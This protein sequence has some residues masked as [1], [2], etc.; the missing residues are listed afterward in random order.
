MFRNYIKTAWRNLFKTKIFSIINITGLAFGLTVFWLITLF[1]ADELSYDKYHEKSDRIFRVVSHGR[2]DGGSFDI[3]GT[4]GPT[5]QALKNEYPEIEQTVRIAPGA[6]GV[7]NNQQNRLKVD[8]IFYGDSSFFSVFTYHFIAG[9]PYRAL[10]APQSIVLTKGLAVKLFG[11]ADAALNKS[12]RFQ[13]DIPSLI[14]GVIEDVPDNS[15]FTFE[16]IRSFPKDFSPDWSNFYLYTYLLLKNK[17]D[18]DVLKKKLP[19]FVKKYFYG[20]G[21]DIKYSLE[22]QPLTS[23]HLHS[24]VSYEP[25]VT[26]SMK[27]IYVFSLI[28]LLVLLIAIINYINITTARASV[29]LKEIAIRKIIGSD[30]KNL[31][32]LFLTESFLIILCAILLSIALAYFLMPVFNLLTVKNLNPWSFGFMHTSLALVIVCLVLNLIGGL[33]PALLLS[34]F[35]IIPALRNKMGNHSFQVFFRKSLVILQFSI[36]IIMIVATIVIYRQL[37]FMTNTDLG[38]DKNEVVTFSFNNQE[39]KINTHDLKNELLKKAAITG[40]AFTGSPM[41]NNDH[42]EMKA[43]NAEKNGAIDANI[44]LAN[45]LTIDEDYIP[46]MRIKIKQGRNFNGLLATDS[47]AVIINEAFAK[48]K[49]WGNAIGK[50][51]QVPADSNRGQ[52][53]KTVIGVTKDFH[54]YSLQHKIEPMVM[55][56]PSSMSNENNAYVR[57]SRQNIGETIQF[58][59]NTFQKF[60]HD[61]PFEYSFLDQNFRKQYESEEKQGLLLLAFTG[62]TITIACLGLF[63]LITFTTNQR[64]KEVGIRKVLG[65]SAPGLVKLLSIELLKLVLLSLLVAFPVSWLVMNT[66]LDEF[67]YRISITWWMFLL[68]GC[69]GILITGVT[70]SFQTIKAATANPVKSLRAE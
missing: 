55:E 7:I 69:I 16:A 60:D 32:S 6:G 26:R 65:A 43:F 17:N 15:H 37:H 28:A 20:R 24:D 70:I 22:L 35:K 13:K 44:T 59:K 30:R 68:A 25:G 2:W 58:I 18:A 29:R 47:N 9:S 62:L 57:V 4:S 49:G 27:S 38:L 8:D 54:A 46:A 34:G 45:G 39:A 21:L 31:V 42:I 14:T 3:T 5:A 10:S 61:T 56:L 51:I 40:V 12:I 67:A 1:I 50:R 23:I 36:T 53:I 33:Y 66:W 48:D 41:G 64:I 11:S 52:L 63:G 19:D